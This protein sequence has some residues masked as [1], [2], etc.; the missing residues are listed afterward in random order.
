MS[1]AVTQSRTLTSPVSRSTSTLATAPP[2]RTPDRRR[3]GR[4]CRR[5]ARRGRG[6][7]ARRPASARPRGRTRRTAA[8]SA[9]RRGSRSFSAAWMS[10]PPTTMAVRDATVGP[11][12]GDDRGVLRRDLDLAELDAERIGDELREDRLRALA[13]LG[14]RGQDADAAVIGQLERR[15]RCELDLAGAGE[16]CAVPGQRQADAGG[17]A[18]PIGPALAHRARLRVRSD[19]RPMP[20]RPPRG[21]RSRRPTRAAP[22]RSA[23]CRPR[24]TPSGGAGRAARRRA[25]RRCG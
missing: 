8:R 4:S 7:T 22:G 9:P 17:H 11:R 20:R 1:S 23:S 3:R 24:G 12:V 6:R 13:H 19:R 21:P 16:P 2:S 10:S 14:R 18:G 15:D 25:P 5:T